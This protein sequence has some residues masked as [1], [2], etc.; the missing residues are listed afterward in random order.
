MN[1]FDLVSPVLV[2]L[3]VA[4]TV[5]AAIAYQI[6]GGHQKITLTFAVAVG[7]ALWMVNDPWDEPFPGA[8]NTIVGIS[9]VLQAVLAALNYWLRNAEI[10][11]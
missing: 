10:T 7:A 2:G 5:A 4:T 9:T 6:T 1:I 3:F 8:L 11:E